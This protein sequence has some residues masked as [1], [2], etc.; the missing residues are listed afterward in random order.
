MPLPPTTAPATF[1][2]EA[3]SRVAAFRVAPR[4]LLCSGTKSS[5]KNAEK[6]RTGVRY[7]GKPTLKL[8]C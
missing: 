1:I 6:H 4:L 7:I 5:A 3:H 8:Y 2:A